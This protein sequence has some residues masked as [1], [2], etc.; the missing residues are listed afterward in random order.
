MQLKL[1]L[2]SAEVGSLGLYERGE[3]RGAMPPKL[4]LRTWQPL[5]LLTP[6]A[7]TRVVRAGVLF[8]TGHGQFNESMAAA[9]SGG[10]R[11]S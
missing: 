3:A 5:P 7:G 10:V 1:R 9:A 11:P 6:V 2:Y 4:L 8:G